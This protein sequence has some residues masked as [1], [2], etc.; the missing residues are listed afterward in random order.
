MYIAQNWGTAQVEMVVLCQELVSAKEHIK[1]LEG[2]A[3]SKRIKGK[4]VTPA[5]T[6][7]ITQ[8]DAVRQHKDIGAAREARKHRQH[9]PIPILADAHILNILGAAPGGSYVGNNGFGGSDI[10]VFKQRAAH[11][12]HRPRVR[13]KY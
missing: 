2:P 3:E 11:E 13:G 10:D 5:N 6:F 7:H 1:R 9:P 8:A 4:L 12:C